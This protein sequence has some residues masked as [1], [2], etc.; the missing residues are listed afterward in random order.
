MLSLLR[1][2]TAMAVIAATT[3]VWIGPAASETTQV[4]ATDFASGMSGWTTGGRYN[5]WGTLTEPDGNVYIADSPSGNYDIGVDSWAM[6]SSTINLSGYGTCTASF[7]AAMDVDDGD[8]LHFE[9]SGNATSWQSVGQWSGSTS[10]MWQTKMAD[11]TPY[12]GQTKLYFRFHFVTDGY[13]QLSGNDGVSLDDLSVSC[14]P[15]VATSPTPTPTASTGTPTATPSPTSTP[16]TPPPAS[17]GTNGPLAWARGTVVDSYDSELWRA[18][19]DGSGAFQLTVDTTR[20][21]QPTFSPDGA[22]LAWA[23]GSDGTQGLFV[24]PAVGGSGKRLTSAGF[25]GGANMCQHRPRWSP[26]GKKIAFQ[27]NLDKIVLMNTDGSGMRVLPFS[28]LLSGFTWSPDSTK[29]V[30]SGMR[31]SESDYDLFRINVDGTGLAR[32]TDNTWDE[33]HPAWSPDGAKI[34]YV[35]D[36][37]DG[38]QILAAGIFVMNADG[39]GQMRITG[40]QDWDDSNPAWSPDGTKIAFSSSRDMNREIYTM[41]TD[42]TNPVRI[43]NDPAPDD[44]PAW[45]A[46]CDA[47]CQQQAPVEKEASATQIVSVK[48]PNSTT[49]KVTGVVAPPHDGVTVAVTLA[50]KVDGVFKTFSTAKGKLFHVEGLEDVSVFNVSIKRARA[51]TCRV[52]VRFPGDDSHKPSSA[53]KIFSC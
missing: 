27:Q 35:S 33:Q 47:T 46:A 48:K 37:S 16:T 40:S 4:F 7:K 45:G 5:S 15:A 8:K 29:L 49:V 53:K 25:C 24:A 38:G 42:G 20:D 28:G 34:A 10:G 44:F 12:A 26:D 31:I 19:A 18:E 43:T 17:T 52:K 2:A 39:T 6:S 32:I 23:R 30:F 36:Y 22:R 9:V 14:T 41:N 50:R 51:G 11:L 1:G 21:T 13:E 3:V